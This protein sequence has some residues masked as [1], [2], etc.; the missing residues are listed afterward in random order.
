MRS[1]NLSSRS[2]TYEIWSKWIGSGGIPKNS[3]SK[4]PSA[5]FSLGPRC[6]GSGKIKNLPTLSPRVEHRNETR[7]PLCGGGGSGRFCGSLSI[8]ASSAMGLFQTLLTDTQPWFSV[9]FRQSCYNLPQSIQECDNRILANLNFFK[10]NYI[11]IIMSSFVFSLLAVP[12]LL[13]W[14]TVLIIGVSYCFKHTKSFRIFDVKIRKRYCILALGILLFYFIYETG[15]SAAFIYA[16]ESSLLSIFVHAV[17]YDQDGLLEIKED[18]K[19]E[20]EVC[21]E[22]LTEKELNL[23]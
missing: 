11:T 6:E 20:I 4:T 23:V 8:G 21:G 3:K 15:I 9:F 5:D 7:N 13:F 2:K 12:S 16:T 18:A 1:E 19:K 10:G 17:T 14:I 22:K